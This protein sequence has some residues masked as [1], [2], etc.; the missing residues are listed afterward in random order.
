MHTVLYQYVELDLFYRMTTILAVCPSLHHLWLICVSVWTGYTLA[1]PT[2]GSYTLTDRDGHLQGILEYLHWQLNAENI[3]A[4]LLTSGAPF[5]T[6]ILWWMFAAEWQQTWLYV[7]PYIINDLYVWQWQLDI[8]LQDQRQGLTH[9]LTDRRQADGFVIG[10]TCVIYADEQS[11][12]TE[13]SKQMQYT[14][15]TNRETANTPVFGVSSCEQ[16]LISL[17]SASVFI[18]AEMSPTHTRQMFTC[19]KQPHSWISDYLHWQL[20]AETTWHKFCQ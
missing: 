2:T 19:C 16:S 7:L 5:C 4:H 3:K 6:S 8:N 18:A 17:L 12:R 10:K 1:G 20:N 9:W 15:Y 14:E 11:K 13:T